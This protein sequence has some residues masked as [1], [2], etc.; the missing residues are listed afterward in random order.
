MFAGIK[1][2]TVNFT[3][4]DKKI[5]L[6]TTNKFAIDRAKSAIDVKTEGRNVIGNVTEGATG[7]VAFYV[8]GVKQLIQLTGSQARWDDVLAIGNNTI[9]VVYGET[10]TTLKAKTIPM[11]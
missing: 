4:A 2:A 10:S 1:T 7:E 3:S 6:T 9:V 5:N 11:L 8:N